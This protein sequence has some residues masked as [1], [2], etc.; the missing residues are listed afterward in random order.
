LLTYYGRSVQVG[1]KTASVCTNFDY[2]MA[3]IVL[4]D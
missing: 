2:Q 1:V 3:L 4:E